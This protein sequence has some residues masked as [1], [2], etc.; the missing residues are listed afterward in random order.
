MTAENRYCQIVLF[1]SS[2]ILIV[3]GTESEAHFSHQSQGGD[4]D[5]T[6]RLTHVSVG[7]PSHV[8]D[9]LTSFGF[10]ELYVLVGHT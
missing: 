4:G 7:L 8:F 5:F 2:C 9:V 6:N 3:I 10:F 1:H